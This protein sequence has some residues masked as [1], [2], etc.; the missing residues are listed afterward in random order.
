MSSLGA[1]HPASYMGSSEFDVRPAIRLQASMIF[2]DPSTYAPSFQ[3]T[4][5]YLNPENNILTVLL[6]DCSIWCLTS[7]IN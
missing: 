1:E 6:C 4:P 2:L 5:K 7:D 3:K